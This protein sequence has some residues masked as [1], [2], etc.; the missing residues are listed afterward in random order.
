MP[1]LLI[2]PLR[3]SPESPARCRGHRGDD[4]AAIQKALDALNQAAQE[5]AKISYESAKAGEGAGAQPDAKKDDVI[6]AEYEVK[7]QK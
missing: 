7:D 6:D 4:P 5:L 3:D 1:S 2:A